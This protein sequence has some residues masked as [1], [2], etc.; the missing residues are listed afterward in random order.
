MIPS[1]IRILIILLVAMLPT[2]GNLHAKEVLLEVRKIWDHARH[3]ALTDLLR[4]RGHWYCVLREGYDHRSSDGAL[5]VLTSSDG[6]QWS[7]AALISPEPDHDL[8]DPHITVTPDDRLMLI[9]A[10]RVGKEFHPAV[11]FSSDGENWGDLIHVGERN[12]WLWRV[13]WYKGTAYGVGYSV[14]NESFTRLY[15]SDDGIHFEVLVKNFFDRESPNETSIVFDDDGTAY[16]LLRRDGE[17][18]NSAQLGVARSP[19][20]DWTWKDLGLRLGGPHMLLL[21]DGR[22]VAAGRLYGEQHRTSLLWL[23]PEGGTMQEFLALP[24]GGDTSYPGLVL[25]DGI[26]WVSYYASPEGSRV[27]ESPVDITRL[28][29]PADVYLAKVRLP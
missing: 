29:A 14:G 21:P 8:R 10:D 4:F 7:S 25:H 27:L 26:L 16:C 12:I 3:N 2:T 6:E 18:E 20:T 5:R 17:T 13:S 1:A 15:R 28:E 11:W 24:S 9:G 22:F 23:D 19:Y